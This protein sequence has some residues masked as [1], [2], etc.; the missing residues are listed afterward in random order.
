[1]IGLGLVPRRASG[2]P[3]RQ[4]SDPWWPSITIAL[5]AGTSPLSLPLLAYLSGG[6]S[7]TV[8]LAL[9]GPL[10]LAGLASAAALFLAPRLVSDR[11]PSIPLCA[12]TI[13]IGLLPAINVAVPAVGLL[14]LGLLGTLL[15]VPLALWPV[16]RPDRH[17]ENAASP[18]GGDDSG[19][20]FG[21]GLV[22]GAALLLLVASPLFGPTLSWFAEAGVG[23]SAGVA[24]SGL[25]RRRLAALGIVLLAIAPL[26]LFG[27]GEALVR[28]PDLVGWLLLKGLPATVGGSP[29][30]PAL[31]TVV[32]FAAVGAT[33]GSPGRRTPVGAGL[34]LVAWLALPPLVG[35]DLALRL[36]AAGL[37]VVAIP[38]VIGT[39]AGWKRAGVALGAVGTLA[40]LV[41]PPA[42]SGARA[43]AP[44]ASFADP[45]ALGRID[46]VASWREAGLRASARGST[47]LLDELD[48]PVFW[49]AGRSLRLDRE[50]AGADSFFAHLPGLLRGDAPA[51]VLVLG[52]GHG[53]VVDSLRRSSAGLVRVREPSPG[54]RWLVTTRG[55][56]NGEVAADPAVRFLAVD[57]TA[58]Q[59]GRQRYDAVLVELPP[60]WVPGGVAG[61]SQGRVNSVA[62]VVA[63]GGVAVFR[64]PLDGL[65]GD[66]LASF[67]DA[68]CDAFPDVT[69][70][71]DPSGASHLLLAGRPEPGAVDAGSLFRAWSRR[72]V[73]EELRRV[74][75][76]TPADVLERLVTNREGLVGMADGRARRDGYGIA[77]VAGARVRSGRRAL[78][79]AALAATPGRPDELFDLSRVPADERAALS[80]RL[81][82]AADARADYLELL[83]ALT[84]GD[85]ITAMEV[86]QRISTSGSASTKDLRTLISPWLDRCRQYRSQGLLEQARS[87][88]MIAVS[89]SPTDADANLLL[90]DVQRLLGDLEGATGSYQGV[91]ERD[92][93]SLGA[94]LGL[95]AVH[96]REQRFSEAAGLLEEAE[97]LHPG[98][99]VL[100]NNLGSVY[101]R[102]ARITPVDQEAATFAARARALFQAAAALEPRMAEPRAGLAEVYASTGE[103][104]KALLEAD[105]AVSLAP[106][107]AWQPLRAELLYLLGRTTEAEAEVDS[108]LLDC[109]DEVTALGTKGL[110]L[111]EKGCY[112]QAKSQ[113]DRVLQVEPG[114]G[115][116]TANLRLLEDSGLLERGDQ[117]CRR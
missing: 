4:A 34:G 109:P 62:R 24:V 29:L 46:Q 30:A 18:D 108:I 42:P 19:L 98:N 74:A 25:V 104:D 13:A 51:S 8:G 97:K 112:L 67:A 37:A 91:R 102:M 79:L 6:L 86:A 57:P 49:S 54:R 21:L 1:M 77:V 53:G 43:V 27:A 95:A 59:P 55:D 60:P 40:C 33:A 3:S 16:E 103:L 114:N 58:P 73:R 92:P 113:W 20:G 52:A 41:I 93:T 47:Y 10:V 71:L 28:G 101:L 64:L 94:A 99:A 66:E 14:R 65:S 70:W 84:Q 110:L 17:P 31:I 116:A 39:G 85:S 117:D 68:V 36:V 11:W 90:G 63:S 106:G 111:N 2:E 75:L 80:D 15:L 115:P 76:F 105:R 9:A 5:I 88:C 50:R 107:C 87:E 26:V 61:W 78:P 56:W 12:I 96:E 23:L 81:G 32:V 69:T 72:A 89:F 83:A 45:S 38:T 35:P 82:R 100:L 48:P 7:A 22:G 44:Y